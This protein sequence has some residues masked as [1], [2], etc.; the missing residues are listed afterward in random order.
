MSFENFFR[1]L[2]FMNIE[3]FGEFKVEGTEIAV[4]NDFGFLLTEIRH[5]YFLSGRVKGQLFLDEII[6]AFIKQFFDLVIVIKLNSYP[7]CISILL[8]I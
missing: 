4:R 1:F 6:W 3:I 2:W 5:I 7:Q 8:K